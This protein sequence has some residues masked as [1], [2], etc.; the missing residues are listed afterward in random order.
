MPR[1]LRH[2]GKLHAD[3]HARQAITHFSLG[4][5]HS[6]GPS[7]AETDVE[8]RAQRKFLHGINEH[9][10]GTDIGGA[11]RDVAAVA[12]VND[13]QVTTKDVAHGGTLLSYNLGDHED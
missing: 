1:R 9:S 7:Q 13:L 5:Y 8:H 3:P 6:H 10:L 4:V 12:F 2:V 11:Q